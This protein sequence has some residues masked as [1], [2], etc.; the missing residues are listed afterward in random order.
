MR[1]IS[2]FCSAL[3][4]RMPVCLF[5]AA[6]L[7]FAVLT[8]PPALAES[9]E[10]PVASCPENADAELFRAAHRG[11]VER[12]KR[13]LSECDADVNARNYHNQTPLTWAIRSGNVDMVSLLL[14]KEADV[15]ARDKAGHTV[16][17]TSVRDNHP[18]M[19]EVILAHFRT[20]VNIKDHY[21]WT[22]MDW[23]A[24]KGNA[25][26]ADVLKDAG[27]VCNGRKELPLCDSN[28]VCERDLH[29]VVFNLTAYGSHFG[30]KI[31][32]IKLFAAVVRDG[33]AEEFARLIDCGVDLDKMDGY[34]GDSTLLHIAAE[35]RLPQIARILLE[36]GAEVNAKDRYGRTPLHDLD[37][38]GY[39]SADTARVLLEYGAGVNAKDNDGWTPLDMFGEIRSRFFLAHTSF[40]SDS[41]AAAA[42][43]REFGG[44]CNV[45][46]HS[47]C[48]RTELVCEDDVNLR[49]RDGWSRLHFMVYNGHVED[50]ER[51]INCGADVDAKNNEGKTPLHRAAHRGWYGLLSGADQSAKILIDSGADVNSRDNSGATPLFYA[52][53]SNA[54]GMVTRLIESGANVNATSNNGGTALHRA[55][56]RNADEAAELLIESGANVNAKDNNR[57]TPLHMAAMWNWIEADAAEL[58]LKNGAD[59]NAKNADSKTPLDLVIEDPHNY[60]INSDKI[61]S[62]LRAY[63]G[64]CYMETHELCGETL[65]TLLP[66][67]RTELD[68]GL[69]SA[70]EANDL[71]GARDYVRRGANVNVANDD[72][73]TPLH[74]AAGNENGLPLAEF[75]LE[76]GADVGA[77][78]GKGWTPLY[79]AL[80]SHSVGAVVRL[81]LDNGA[82]ANAEYV[83]GDSFSHT[84]LDYA[85]LHHRGDEILAMLTEAGGE[86]RVDWEE[87]PFSVFG[88]DSNAAE[89]CSVNS[90]Q[91]QNEQLSAQSDAARE[92]LTEVVAEGIDALPPSFNALATDVGFTRD[93]KVRLNARRDF[94]WDG[95]DWGLEAHIG[96]VG[97]S[98][99]Q[100]A[101]TGVGGSKD[102]AGGWRVIGAAKV[103]RGWTQLEGG[104]ERGALWASEFSAGFE[105]LGLFYGGDALGFG[106]SQPLYVE[107]WEAETADGRRFRG[108]QLSG[109][110]LNVDASYRIPLPGGENGM[111]EFSA[112]VGRESGSA[113][114]FEGDALISAE[115]G[116]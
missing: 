4:R 57:N 59:V 3:F 43:L 18:E 83:H 45:G 58:L 104:L 95:G 106:V 77:N 34:L 89:W 84:P 55:A 40:T 112:A 33:D 20:D 110:V 68:E 85:I 93:M 60:S 22:A 23:A 42:V 36:N 73:D 27:G 79:Q 54:V 31:G 41:V 66:A 103:A 52:A 70:A 108:S 10:N 115:W 44:E 38:H 99:S 111:M 114:G 90:E 37:W 92:D 81:L 1:V 96:A 51:L 113:S 72:G 86:C 50:V 63:G 11:N 29:E 28:L 12:A 80:F 94:R 61:V 109:R 6:A 82:D 101:F 35:L 88:R 46:T 53:W 16:L 116:F 30:A 67:E 107:H 75:L 5:G 100:A 71:A 24:V 87:F 49:G 19:V 8:T 78:A 14:D 98:D 102:F 64:G 26:L 13:L 69:L 105:R 97:E 17:H 65:V 7:A 76:N 21:G 2:S 15:H 25:H 39:G 32:E 48:G 47:L 9:G 91:S 56:K 74:F 62:V